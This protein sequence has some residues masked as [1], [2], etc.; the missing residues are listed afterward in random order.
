MHMGGSGA[1]ALMSFGLGLISASIV[2]DSN[3]NLPEMSKATC[4]RMMEGSLAVVKRAG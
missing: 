4:E 3:W 1:Y 2:P